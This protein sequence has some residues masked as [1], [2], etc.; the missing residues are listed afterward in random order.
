MGEGAEDISPAQLFLLPKLITILCTGAL[1]YSH[2]GTQTAP[3]D[4]ISGAKAAPNKQFHVTRVSLSHL[5]IHAHE[6]TADHQ[7]E[8]PFLG[9]GD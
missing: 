1:L 2:P 6:H 9:A 7:P 8:K 5:C 3:Y 4:D